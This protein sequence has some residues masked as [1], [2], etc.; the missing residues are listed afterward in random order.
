MRMSPVTSKICI[1]RRCAR[2]GRRRLIRS[3][4]TP[5]AWSASMTREA[6]AVADQCPID[7]GRVA[8]VIPTITPLSS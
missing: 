1:A 3:T 2:A 7:P 6:K 4:L 8:S 5:P